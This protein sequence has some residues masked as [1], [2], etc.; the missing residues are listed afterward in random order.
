MKDSEEPVK[1]QCAS[2]SERHHRLVVQPLETPVQEHKR[3][4]LQL[5]PDPWLLDP[6]SP[7]VA[8]HRSQERLLALVK[9]LEQ[10]RQEPWDSR[11]DAEVQP[12]VRRSLD[13]RLLQPQLVAEPELQ[14]HEPCLEELHQRLEELRQLQLQPEH[15]PWEIVELLPEPAQHRAWF[16]VARLTTQLLQSRPEL[17]EV[18]AL[19][20]LRPP[21]H[22]HLQLDLQERHSQE[23]RELLQ[24]TADAEVVTPVQEVRLTQTWVQLVRRTVELHQELPH[25]AP[26]PHRLPR[27]SHE[28]PEKLPEVSHEFQRPQQVTQ[29]LCLLQVRQ[30]PPKKLLRQL[31][32]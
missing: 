30:K 32:K 17:P 21:P 12:L 8:A 2:P 1:E 25:L 13:P 16:A 7:L 15:W 10:L 22:R 11:V 4:V 31:L 9:V 26:L 27:N 20:P 14:D 18:V 28:R 29:L 19:D 24:H 3:V 6:P 5:V 23:L